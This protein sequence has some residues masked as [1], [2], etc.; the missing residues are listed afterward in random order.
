MTHD[1]DRLLNP[2]SIAVVG[3]GARPSGPARRIVANLQSMN[4]DG[5]L[6]LVNP[7]YDTLLDLECHP[8]MAAIGVPVDLAVISVPAVDVAD[9]LRQGAAIGI[10][11]Y[12][13]LSSGFAEMGGGGRK[14]EEEIK[15]I[16]RTHDL[17]IMGANC[18]GSINFHKRK[19]LS[20]TAVFEGDEF[21][22][23]PVAYIGQSG[24]MGPIFYSMAV[25]QGI[26]FSHIISSG[27]E[28]THGL[29]DFVEYLVDDPNTRIIV[30][31]AEQLKNGRRLLELGKKA[32]A[33]NKH[34]VVFKSA[35]ASAG[36]RAAISHTGSLAGNDAICSSLFGRSGIVKVR[37]LE[38]LVAVCKLLLATRPLPT[39]RRTAI[40]AISGGTAVIA[41]DLVEENGFEVPTLRPDTRM[42]LKEWLPEFAS[43]DNPIDVT[44]GLFYQPEKFAQVLKCLVEDS[45]IDQIV[46]FG[47]YKHDIAQRLAEA[48][49]PVLA[50]CSKY[51]IAAWI[52]GGPEISRHFTE[53]GIP[54]FNNLAQG[55]EA[56]NLI[57]PPSS[58]VKRY[59]KQDVGHAL[60][61]ADH[62]KVLTEDVVKSELKAFGVSVLEEVVASSFQEASDAA[63][64]VGFPVAMKVISPDIPHRAKVGGI[65]LGLHSEE[66]VAAEFDRM[67]ARVNERV[68]AA[69]AES[70]VVQK[71]VQPGP[72]LLVGVS[73]DPSFGMVLTFGLGGILTEALQQVAFAP[74]PVAI[75]DARK[76]V[77]DVPAVQALLS[78]HPGSHEALAV[79]ITQ[80]SDWCMS[81]AELKELDLNPVMFDDGKPVLID[82]LA[83]IES[84]DTTPNVARLNSHEA[85]A[86]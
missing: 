55:F 24:A 71:M 64:Q 20:F 8:S 30:A 19:H 74:L 67:L 3:I 44:S 25:K 86:L 45:G 2:R 26:G 84:L 75:E 16:A 29:T 49:A 81:K 59:E 82:G 62:H 48:S 79:L 33:A 69:K 27:N 7:K 73:H 57:V 66:A 83:V 17:I 56:L 70:V 85:A 61:S 13:I 23:G 21:L 68:P 78:F 53:A 14:L 12:M 41:A 46:L 38:E 11:N 18:A 32:K 10:R 43:F 15:D 72:E 60:S 63:K 76:L 65:A 37:T 5:A 52:S 6:H 54:Y 42:R 39:G 34:L 31:Y 4:F 50:G 9:V 36:A 80:V 47:A 40:L 77:N 22:E 1:F 28:T 51:S 35:R 58:H